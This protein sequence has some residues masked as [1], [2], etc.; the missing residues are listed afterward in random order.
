MDNEEQ[1]RV[2][3]A[4]GRTSIGFPGPEILFYTFS[5]STHSMCTVFFALMHIQSH[6]YGK[7]IYLLQQI[8]NSHD[9]VAVL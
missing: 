7:F 8:I 2:L 5:K 1:G 6:S 9:K 4:M 3:S